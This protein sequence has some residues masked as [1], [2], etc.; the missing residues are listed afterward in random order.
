M[1]ERDIEE[2]TESLREYFTDKFKR[3]EDKFNKFKNTVI[4]DMQNQD[5]ANQKD[6]QTLYKKTD[7]LK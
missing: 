4:K 2:R 3:S 1:K 5:E 6:I 7:E